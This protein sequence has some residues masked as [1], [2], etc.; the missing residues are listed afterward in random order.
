MDI[1]C[2]ADV[3][4][5]QARQVPDSQALCFEGEAVSYG[6]LDT[7]SSQCAQA[8]IASGVQPGDRIGVLAK[9]NA[10]FFVLWMGCLKAG[11][12]LTPVNWRLAA[13]EVAFIL[14]DAGCRL[15]VIGADY[16]GLVANLDLPDLTT[17]IQFEP[18]HGEWPGF[19]E[20]GRAHV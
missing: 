15:A 4:R 16:A 8:L 7:L 5:V 13:P 2:V 1:Q 11:A 19:R 14:G 18:G 20:I 9:G 10:D 12:C 3:A 6:Q 17:R